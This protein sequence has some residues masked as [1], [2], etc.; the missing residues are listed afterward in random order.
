[1]PVFQG[2]LGTGFAPS[3]HPETNNNPRGH[4]GAPHGSPFS[5]HVLHRLLPRKTARP[6]EAVG[7]RATLETLRRRLG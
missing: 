4:R 1:M 6:H 7:G 2:R 3:Q 5:H